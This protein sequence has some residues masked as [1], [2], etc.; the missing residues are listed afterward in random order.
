MS[1]RYISLTIG[2]K[3]VRQYGGISKEECIYCIKEFLRGDLSQ[4]LL[5][6]WNIK[7]DQDSDNCEFLNIPD[8]SF[9]EPFKLKIIKRNGSK[10]KHGVIIHGTI[11]RFS[12]NEYYLVG[13]PTWHL[14]KVTKIEEV[15]YSSNK[16]LSLPNSGA[17]A[18]LDDIIIKYIKERSSL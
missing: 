10:N 13:I 6:G 8:I 4:I 18:F 3:I 2:S 17:K 7:V 1:T 5:N 11:K 15:R 14:V 12:K 9:P 16:N